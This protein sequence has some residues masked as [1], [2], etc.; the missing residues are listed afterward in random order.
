MQDTTREDARRTAANFR[1]RAELFR[2]AAAL[3]IEQGA[4]EQAGRAAASAF[5]LLDRAE[6][7][8]ARHGAAVAA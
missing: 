6:A 2:R 4:H 5:A 3:F 1:E 8:L 7:V